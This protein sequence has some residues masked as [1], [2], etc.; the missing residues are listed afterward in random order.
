MTPFCFADILFK[1]KVL[2]KRLVFDYLTFYV[3]K[4]LHDES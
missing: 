2:V 4:L 3:Y 1:L